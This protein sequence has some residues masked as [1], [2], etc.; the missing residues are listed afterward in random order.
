MRIG[1][2]TQPRGAARQV[3]LGAMMTEAV[4][5]G[6]GRDVV[7]TIARREAVRVTG[8][9]RRATLRAMHSRRHVTYSRRPT[10]ALQ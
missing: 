2:R 3:A 5:V 8:L 6:G 1:A 4:N 10:K 9:R 7:A